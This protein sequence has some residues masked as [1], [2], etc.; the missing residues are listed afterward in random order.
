M[1][2]FLAAECALTLVLL[3]AVVMG[4]RQDLAT[5]RRE[6]HVNE[7]VLTMWVT[8]PEAAY[9]T[10]ADRA[11]FYTR[12]QERLTGLG[13]GTSAGLASA[14]P[15]GGGVTQDVTIRGRTHPAGQPAPTALTVAVDQR[16]FAV[17]GIPIR[18]V[19]FGAPADDV[20]LDRVIVNERFVQLFLPGRDPMGEHIRLGSS[21]EASWLEIVGVVPSVRQRGGQDIDPV[22]YRPVRATAPATLAIVARA[23]GAPAALAAPLRQAVGEVD[24]N[25]PLYRTMTLDQ[26][27]HDA[28]WNARL[29]NVLLRS[30]ALIAGALALVG[31]Y[32]VTAHAVGQR[33]RELGVLAA[34]GARPRQLRWLVLRPA[35]TP[36]AGGLAVGFGCVS[37]FERLF[38]DPEQPIAMTDIA[39]LIPLV[40][41]VVVVAAVACLIPA[42][43]AARI[44]PIAAL[45]SE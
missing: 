20:W 31:L 42:R 19:G 15:A 38:D 12:L 10:A 41:T 23:A 36:L 22:V 13:P 7:G 6:F 40:G 9:G 11:A 8:L 30:I 32:A 2:S 16:Y 43:R 35:M 14:L 39:T 45:R 3:A 24:P 44:D 4:A 27:M 18:G 33:R 5:A 17:T 1:A 28:R 21:P 37:L 26:A 29:S 25:V 34:L